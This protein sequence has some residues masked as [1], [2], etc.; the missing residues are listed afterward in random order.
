[1]QADTTSPQLAPNQQPRTTIRAPP[2][3]AHPTISVADH[4]ES[5]LLLVSSGWRGVL[6]IGRR[7]PGLEAKR[8]VRLTR[9]ATCR[10]PGPYRGG[11]PGSGL[12]EEPVCGV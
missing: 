6:R 12:S 2:A 8:S 10:G 11:R 4:I 7:V 1:M 5:S 9:G 3:T